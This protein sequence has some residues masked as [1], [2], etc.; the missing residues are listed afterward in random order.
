MAPTLRLLFELERPPVE[1]LR[2]SIATSRRHH[3]NP[4]EAT[5]AL[6]GPR[7][8]PVRLGVVTTT[9]ALF[10]MKVQRKERNGVADL[11]AADQSSPQKLGPPI[12]AMV[13]GNG[14]RENAC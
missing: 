3:S 12:S 4:A 14:A 10:A 7:S 1:L 9:H 2:L 6:A 11:V 13:L 8:E 5:R